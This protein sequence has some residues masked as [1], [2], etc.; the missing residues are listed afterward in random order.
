MSGSHEDVQVLVKEIYNNAHLLH[1]YGHQLNLI[2]QSATSQNTRVRIFFSSLSGI[3][4]EE[5]HCAYGETQLHLYSTSS[6]LMY[7]NYATLLSC[8]EGNGFLLH[9]TLQ[10]FSSLVR[11]S[12][13]FIRTH[14]RSLC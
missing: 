12:F 5:P 7:A 2:S 6:R 14:F 11:E 1:C 13:R 3:V 8:N 9:I 10:Q 4:V